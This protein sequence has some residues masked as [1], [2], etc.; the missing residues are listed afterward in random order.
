MVK[1]VTFLA[2]RAAAAAGTGDL[3]AV[4]TAVGMVV[5]REPRRVWSQEVACSMRGF[6]MSWA[7]VRAGRARARARAWVRCIFL[8]QVRVG[9][10]DGDIAG[11]GKAKGRWKG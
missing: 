3:R 7:L 2:A 1:G 5:G 8:G 9:E 10:S 4:G 6:W 11:R